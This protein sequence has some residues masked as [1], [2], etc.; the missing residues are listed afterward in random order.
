VPDD[1]SIR[2]ATIKSLFSPPELARAESGESDRVSASSVARA[3]A[4]LSPAP[5]PAG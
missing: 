1:R 2:K 5:T 4:D 3:P